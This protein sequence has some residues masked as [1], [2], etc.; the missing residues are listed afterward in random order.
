M[1]KLSVIIPVYGV[2]RYI[3]RCVESLLAQALDDM[4]F[5]FVDDHTPDDSIGVV[6]RMIEGHPR[7]HQFVFLQTPQNGGAGPARNYGLQH[8][9]GEYIGFVDSDDWVSADGY[10]H[11]YTKAKAFDADMCFGAAVKNFSDGRPDVLI[12]NPMLP[13]GEVSHD[14]LAAFLANYVSF[15]TTFIYRRSMLEHNSLVF[16]GGG[17]SEDSY[18]LATALLTA[19]RFA[20]VPDVFY[21]YLIRPASAS[22]SVDET[23]YQ[24]RMTIF[25]DVLSFARER[26]AYVSFGPE[27]DFM[28][29]KKGSLSTVVNYIHNCAHPQVAVVRKLAMHL[30]EQ[31]PDAGGNKYVKQ[32]P[33]LRAALLLLRRCPRLFIAF[34]RFLPHE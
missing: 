2:E 34:S 25:D 20:S 16:Y 5:L 6:K 26:G 11:L 13:D 8:A 28:Y 24:K 27:I 3:G 19:K 32:K 17:W 9:T 22:T 18:F 23:K 21:H 33:P 15:F 7:E 10:L 29:I 12:H 30:Y 14:D 4:E 1:T 31:V